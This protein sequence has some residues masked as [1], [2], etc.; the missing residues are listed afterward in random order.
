MSTAASTKEQPTAIG[1]IKIFDWYHEKDGQ[2]H[3]LWHSDNCQKREVAPKSRV[4]AKIAQ[5]HKL[6]KVAQKLHCTRSQFSGGTNRHKAATHYLADT[7][8]KNQ[9]G[10]VS[11]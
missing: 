10:V 9:T 2:D 5:I 1:G 8:Q 4:V 11:I 6:A 3:A 7:A